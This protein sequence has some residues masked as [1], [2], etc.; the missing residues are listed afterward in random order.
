VIVGQVL[1]E[2][3][4]ATV[5]TAEAVGIA[6]GRVVAVGSREALLAAAAPH[7]T[8]VR[9]DDAAVVP[10]LHDFHLHLVGMARALRT[11]DLDGA[12]S[13]DALVR[14]VRDAAAGVAAGEW[15]RGDGWTDE[16]LDRAGLHRLEA[17]LGGRPALLRSH[18]RHSAW[19][20]AEALRR[21]GIGAAPADPEGGRFERG[22]TG[23]PDGVLRERAADLVAEHAGRLSGAGLAGA[24]DEVVRALLGLGVTAVTDAGDAGAANGV[25]L[26]AALGDSF[27]ELAAAAPVLDGR[28]RVMLDI[29]AAAI[30]AARE[31]GLRTGTVLAGA[32]TMRIGWAKVYADGALGSRTAAVFAPYRCGDEG[33]GILRLSPDQLDDVVG[34]ARE[35]GIGLAIHA[36][37]DRATAAVLDALARG[38][39]PAAGAIPDRIEHLQLVRPADV[40]RLAALEV[41]ASLQPL[42]CP[43]DRDTAERCWPDRLDDAYPWGS[44]AAAGTRLAFGSDAPIEAAN[45]WLAIHAAVH[46]RRPGEPGPDWLPGQA[47]AM[48]AALAASTRGPAA[49]S[50]WGDVGHLHPGA[51]AD[52]AVLSCGLGTILEGGPSLGDVTSVMTMV[53]GTVVH[54]S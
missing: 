4:A 24:L 44:L 17:V 18:D 49:G 53:R 3:H 9:A 50:G 51:W 46:R 25:G 52:L 28:L 48:G 40:P 23:R 20:S 5:E 7:A 39:R 41:T 35:A 33:T 8:V 13:M 47:L 2:A 32:Q 19:A 1:L 10:G 54:G 29:P 14:A 21:A 36:I 16:A 31:A 34:R 6:A 30:G 22:P 38:P 11:V 37:G 26:H 42:H 43:S 12:R 45:P 27:S 15:V